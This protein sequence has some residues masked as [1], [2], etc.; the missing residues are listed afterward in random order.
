MQ[1]AALSWPFAQPPD[2]IWDIQQ[3]FTHYVF[4]PW[5]APYPVVSPQSPHE[6]PGLVYWVQGSWSGVPRQQ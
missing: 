4:A 1:G 6:V 5:V 2:L 3:L